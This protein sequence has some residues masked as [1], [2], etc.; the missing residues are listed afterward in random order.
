M[1]LATES[2]E[3]VFLRTVNGFVLVEFVMRIDHK[4]GSLFI[5]VSKGKRI[6]AGQV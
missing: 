4:F 3:Y 5:A 1:A 2:S 6:F